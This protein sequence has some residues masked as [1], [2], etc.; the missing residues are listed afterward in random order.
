MREALECFV[1]DFPVTHSPA[2]ILELAEGKET[3]ELRW[4]VRADLG[5][6]RQAQYQATLLNVKLLRLLGGREFR[7]SYVTLTLDIRQKDIA[8]IESRLGCTLHARAATN[9]IAFPRSDE[10][11]V[12]QECV[13]TCRSRWSPYHY[14][15]KPHKHK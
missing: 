5:I 11:R 13:S 7:T 10:R 14:K 6:N 12:G 3:T 4:C 15:K 8:E 1:N 9:A 2:A